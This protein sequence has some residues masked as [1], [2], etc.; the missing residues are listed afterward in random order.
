MN[1]VN[2]LFDMSNCLC[3]IGSLFS[4]REVARNRDVL[5]GYS[6]FGSGLIVGD[7]MLYLI[8]M[9]LLGVY[10]VVLVFPAFSY[11]CLVFLYSLRIWFRKKIEKSYYS[12]T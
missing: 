9:Y 2:L 1:I 11:W 10:T 6:I 5:K 3:I 4:I 8:A 7:L 12:R